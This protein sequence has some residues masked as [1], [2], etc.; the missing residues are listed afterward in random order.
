MT[1]ETENQ[2]TKIA[3]TFVPSTKIVNAMKLMAGQEIAVLKLLDTIKSA[4]DE[5]IGW[6]DENNDSDLTELR[7]NNFVRLLSD[8]APKLD[9]IQLWNGSD[10]IFMQLTPTTEEVE[11]TKPEPKQITSVNPIKVHK[12]ILSTIYLTETKGLNFKNKADVEIMLN[13][14]NCFKEK[15][16]EE[17]MNGGDLGSL[18][19]TYNECLK[20]IKENKEKK[21]RFPKNWEENLLK[22]LLDDAWILGKSPDGDTT[23]KPFSK[24]VEGWVTGD[25]LHPTAIGDWPI[26]ITKYMKP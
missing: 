1:N 3:N 21:T 23:V 13:C 8:L 26:R 20:Y 22:S 19:L 5:Y 4:S 18:V 7:R 2:K 9:A 25:K 11:E 12:E 10:W 6:R 15:Y 17:K 24:G 14:I 16:E